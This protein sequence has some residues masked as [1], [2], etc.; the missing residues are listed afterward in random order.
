MT[1]KVEET[2]TKR[3]KKVIKAKPQKAEPKKEKSP[4]IEIKN[5]KMY[6]TDSDTDSKPQAR[7][8]LGEFS[9]PYSAVIEELKAVTSKLDTKELPKED[10][11]K[12]VLKSYPSVGSLTK[13]KV[14]FNLNTDEDDEEDE[15]KDVS[16]K[17][18]GSSTSITSS[19]F[20]A[21]P[22][23]EDKKKDKE[24]DIEDLSDFDFSD[25]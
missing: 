24:K 14:L 5:R 15:K 21:T 11:T 13:K 19:V 2:K 3:L 18:G 10:Q 6:D 16:F 4:K 22:R 8:N 1:K 17:D 25:M 9:A 23:K 7:D 12:G 20:D